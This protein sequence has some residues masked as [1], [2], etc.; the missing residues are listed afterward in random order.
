[1]KNCLKTA[2]PLTLFSLNCP[3]VKNKALSIADLVT[4]RNIDILAFTET[5]LGTSID[6]QVMFELVHAGYVILHV[7]R[8]D[9]RVGGVAV[10][11]REGL[12]LNIIQ[13]IKDGIFTLISVTTRI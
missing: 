6:A 2:K 13:S 7:A 4:S 10:L 1:V 5:W 8:P 9:K 11:F 3:S 12:V